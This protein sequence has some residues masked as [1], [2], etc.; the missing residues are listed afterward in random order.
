MAFL[1]FQVATEKFVSSLPLGYILRSI[2]LQSFF[3]I[4]AMLY[5]HV[6]LLRKHHLITPHTG[7]PVV[8][9]IPQYFGEDWH[10]RHTGT[11]KILFQSRKKAFLRAV[12]IL[13]GQ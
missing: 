6:V 8:A 3:L 2:A 5:L 10:G 4:C 12:I 9:E 7:H 11:C 1:L 13:F